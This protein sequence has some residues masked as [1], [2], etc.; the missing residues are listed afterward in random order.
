MVSITGERL[1]PAHLHELRIESAI[2]D[3]QIAARG[4]ETHDNP[5]SIP[6]PFT[7]EQRR[8]GYSIP[9]WDVFGAIGTYQ[10]K[11]N[12][13]RRG[14]DGKPIKYETPRGGR[15]CLDVP[16][17]A[18][19]YLRDAE[20][21]LWITEGAKKVDSAVCHGIP[22]IIGLLGVSMWQSDG[23]SLP[24]WKEIALKGR[25]VVLAFDSDVMVKASVRRQLD[26]LAAWLTM[27]GAAVRYCL[28]PP[29]KGQP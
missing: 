9:I 26:D 18:L 6:P 22:C 29:R 16:A 13:P 24:D 3:D 11:P 28:I 14:Q 10:L 20:A 17:S 21:E 8:P 27:K 15:V 12:E 1:S 2:S 5:R 7:G 19:P 25:P 4:Y 23:Q